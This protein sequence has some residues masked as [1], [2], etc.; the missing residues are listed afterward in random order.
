MTVSFTRSFDALRQLPHL[1]TAVVFVSL[2]IGITPVSAQLRPA[3]YDAKTKFGLIAILLTP[4]GPRITQVTV[5]SR[6]LFV[7]VINRSGIRTAHVSLT[8]G[9]P[10]ASSSIAD[11]A[12]EL[13]GLDHKAGANDQTMLIDLEPGTYYL[14]VR[15]KLSWTV[16]VIVNP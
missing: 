13:A 6:P 7:T 11:V 2:L 12:N 1:S 9:T 16:R 10:L 4:N 8:K 14:T 5:P 15:E 3:A